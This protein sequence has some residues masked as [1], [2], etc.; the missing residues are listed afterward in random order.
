MNTPVYFKLEGKWSCVEGVVGGEQP[1]DSS[2]PSCRRRAEQPL[3]GWLTNLAE[4]PKELLRASWLWWHHLPVVMLQDFYLFG[5]KYNRVAPT[6]VNLHAETCWDMQLEQKR[7]GR[8][9]SQRLH[10]QRWLLTAHS[11]T[12][13]QI[14]DLGLAAAD[15]KAL[16]CY[17]LVVAM[18]LVERVFSDKSSW[19]QH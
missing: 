4:L 19:S 12:T 3:T 9:P 7:C 5:K 16:S 1:W 10:R 15:N 8:C 18:I 13:G 11:N 17:S 2:S 6:P 14:T